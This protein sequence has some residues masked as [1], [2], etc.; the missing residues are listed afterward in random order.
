MDQRTCIKFCVKNEIKCADAFRMLTVAYGE[1][2]L[3]RSN[4][5]WWYKMFSE[6]REDVNDE[7]RAGRPS[8]STTDEKINEVEKMIL[9]NC[10]I[11]VRE[12]A[13]DLNISIGSCHLIFIND[14]GMRRVAAKFVPKLLNCNQK[15]HHM[16]IANEMLDSVRDDPNLLQRV[17]TGNEA[18]LNHLMEAAARTKTE[19]A[20]QVRSNVKVLLTVFFDCRFVVHHEF[21]PQG[22]TVNKE[23]YLQVMR[24][25]REAIRQKRPDLWKNK[26]WLLHH[27]N[28]PAHTSLLVRD[29]LAKN[30]TLMMLQPPYS[31]D[32]APCDFFLFPKLKRPMKGRRYATLDE[33]KTASK[34]ELKKILKNDFFEVL[35]RLEKTVGTSLT[36]LCLSMGTSTFQKQ[37]YSQIRGT[38]MGSP[39]SSII[40]EIVL[41][42][43]DRWINL[44][45]PSDIYY[46][47]RY[48]HSTVYY[49]KT[50]PPQYTH[51]SS[52]SPIAYK[53]NTVRTLSKRNFTHCSLT[54]FKTIEK[55]RI[56]SILIKAGYPRPF[57]YRHFYDP[58]VSKSTTIHR[59]SCFLPY[60]TSSLAISRIL[61]PFGIKVYYNSSPCLATLLRH[62]ITKADN[63]S[64]PIHSTG[65]VYVVSCQ[66]C[67]S[68]YVGE[69]GRTTYIRLTEHKRNIHNKDPKSLIYQHTAQ[70]GHQFNLDQPKILYRGKYEDLFV[71]ALQTYGMLCIGLYR[72]KDTTSSGDASSKR[73]VI[74]SPPGNYSL[75]PTD[76]FEALPNVEA[77]AFAVDSNMSTDAALR[78]RLRDKKVLP[79]GGDVV[80]RKC[81]KLPSGG[82]CSH[83][84]AIITFLHHQHHVSYGQREFIRVLWHTYFNAN[85]LTLI[86]SLITGGATP[87]LELIL[88]EGAGL[89]GG[90]ST[91]ESLA[92]RDRCRVGQISLAE[93]PLAHYG[94]VFLLP[95]TSSTKLSVEEERILSLGLRFIPPNK[96]NSDIPKIIA[97][98]EGAIGSLNH[99]ETLKVRNAVTQVLYRSTQ[100]TV[101]SNR[102]HSTINRLK[103]SRSIV[104]TKSDKGNQTMILDSAEYKKKMLEILTD[105][106]TFKPIPEKEKNILIKSFKKSIRNMKKL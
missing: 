20:N 92:N 43:L 70:T 95:Y 57:I 83:V 88:A 79:D 50:I 97:G 32:L 8:T 55:A 22:R 47:R 89:R 18:W 96:S 85:A 38:P 33:I 76:M 17:I 78:D 49:K 102:Y 98:V 64:L 93:G 5:Y 72:Y 87:E 29:F 21:L 39:L 28:A 67:S 36:K 26:N 37:Y 77:D 41:G 68:T 99:V 56:V 73:F 4:V 51:F 10:R 46:W 30:N 6:G 11:I 42:F 54:I 63:P 104:I 19:K 58:S 75:L 40:S 24:N 61:C 66:D 71:A 34:E 13:E 101:A 15:Q 90:Y 9:A 94:N 12:V 45:L 59:T 103:K 1:A 60:S 86:R 53:I 16:N 91:P 2:T 100:Q 81:S 74:T 106:D 69:T 52:N 31:P 84:P 62:P 44:T 25:L 48:F 14:L 35:R 65:A 3:D 105:E 23:Y 7:E 80:S 82:R 27:D